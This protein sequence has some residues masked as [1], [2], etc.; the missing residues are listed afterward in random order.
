M[1]SIELT[2]PQAYDGGMAA[3]RLKAYTA[4]EYDKKEQRAQLIDFALLL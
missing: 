1:R 3:H 2:R 4:A